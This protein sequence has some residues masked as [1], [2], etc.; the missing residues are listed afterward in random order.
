SVA[1]EC[2][3][4]AMPTFHLY[5]SGKKIAEVVGADIAQ[6]ERLV[7]QH[8]T[9]SDSA[10]GGFPA[11]GGRVL[12]TGAPASAAASGGGTANNSNFIMLVVLAVVLVYLYFKKDDDGLPQNWED[13]L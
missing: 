1:Q 9:A 10:G 4:R 6:V 5:R 2:G 8:A 7:A 13:S 12:G 11:T 3:I